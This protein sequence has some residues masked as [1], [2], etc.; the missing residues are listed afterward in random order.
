MD[1]ILTFDFKKELESRLH[2][3]WNLLDMGI[4]NIIYF[5]GGYLYNEFGYPVVITTLY[6]TQEEQDEIYKDNEKYKMCS[7]KSFHQLG[8]AVDFR[9]R[10]F[11][12]TTWV[13]IK[14]MVI[15][16]FSIHEPKIV[17]HTPEEIRPHVHMEIH[18][19]YKEVFNY[20]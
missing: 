17:I 8:M 2:T 18:K 13:N 16:Y 7:W 10:P 15:K 9:F 3:E 14:S 5:V 20:D 11:S 19:A 1:K 12:L 6:R 4:K